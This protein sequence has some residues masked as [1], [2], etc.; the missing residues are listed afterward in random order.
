MIR[1]RLWFERSLKVPSNSPPC[2]TKTDGVLAVLSTLTDTNGNSPDGQ[3][4]DANRAAAT[5][6]TRMPASFVRCCCSMS[7]T[8]AWTMLSKLP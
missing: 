3:P 6:W 7:T 1:T 4:A 2:T 8:K 5:R